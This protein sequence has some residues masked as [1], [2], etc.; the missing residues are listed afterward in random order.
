MRSFPFTLGVIRFATLGWMAPAG[1]TRAYLH[2]VQGGAALLPVLL[3][4]EAPHLV[5]E[6]AD[7]LENRDES[8]GCPGTRTVPT[9]LMF[10]NG[11][12][13]RRDFC[14]LP[15]G[16]VA[17]PHGRE[18][19]RRRRGGKGTSRRVGDEKGKVEGQSL[20]KQA[21]QGVRLQRKYAVFPLS[22]FWVSLFS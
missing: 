10:T 1:H 12:F 5:D 6:A 14:S 16:L 17:H 2:L 8:R 18:R 4:E 13:P 19:E 21:W 20:R 22:F 9:F 15:L 11:F 7:D 3:G